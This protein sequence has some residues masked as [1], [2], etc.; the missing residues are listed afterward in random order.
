MYTK[1]A[2]SLCALG[3]LVLVGTFA[4]LSWGEGIR[5]IFKDDPVGTGPVGGRED[6]ADPSEERAENAT[7]ETV[8]GSSDE[9]NPDR[10]TQ[11][12][13]PEEPA[14]DAGEGEVAG[15]QEVPSY[16]VLQ[17]RETEEVREILIKTGATREQQMRL[18]AEDLRPYAPK[19]G[20]LL[21]EFRREA[22]N[23]ALEETG[24]AL[25]FDSRLAATAPYLSYTEEE[26]EA[27]FEEEG[28]IRVVGYEEFKEENQ[29]LVD[30]LES[31]LF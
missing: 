23:V 13:E 19:D 21:L 28:G 26:K 1:L 16:A 6:A 24:F 7:Q 25:V 14:S 10:P 20:I 29:N 2:L 3:V 27:T 11:T 8:G 31:L 12:T 9:P 22:E 5:N 30:E 15:A 18:V 4:T 17:E